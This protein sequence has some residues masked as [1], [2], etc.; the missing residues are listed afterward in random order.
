MVSQILSLYT[1]I[2]KNE[3]NSNLDI[4]GKVGYNAKKKGWEKTKWIW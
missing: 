4:F 3:M 1:K 2:Y